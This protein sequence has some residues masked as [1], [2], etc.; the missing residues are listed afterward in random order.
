MPVIPTSIRVLGRSMLAVLLLGATALG[1]AA[2]AGS[3][4]AAPVKHALGKASKPDSGGLLSDFNGDG[5]DDLA[6]S[7]FGFEVDSQISAGAVSV[8]YGSA[9]G[10]NKLGN[11]LWTEN[12]PGMGTVAES[13]DLWGRA[14]AA[15]D[16]NGDG[17]AD[18]AI[19]DG[20]KDVTGIVDAGQANVIYGSANGL[21]TFAGPGAQ[22]FTQ[23]SPDI[24]DQAE[25]DDN[26]GRSVF[27]GDFNADGYADLAVG[28]AY[29]DVGSIQAA[30]G[31]A[32]IYGTANGLDAL[33]GPG[34]QF[35]TQDSPG[36]LEE[37]QIQDR[38][39]WN[40]TSADWNLDGYADLAISASGDDVNGFLLAGVVNVLLG[41][42]TGLTDVGNQIW[43]ED[44]P[45]IP[46][47]AEEHDAF[48]RSLKST[49][50]NGDG[51]PDLA[52]GAPGEGV[53]PTEIP[54]AGAAF[55]IYGSAIG[56][57]GLAGP[58]AQEFTQ[59]TPGI[60]DLA[61]A[62]DLFGRHLGVGDFNGDGYGD[63]V[64]G[65]VSEDVGTITDAGAAE[66][67]YGSATGLMTAGN[68]FWTQDSKHILG[69]A[70]LYDAMGRA[71]QGFDFNADGY[72]DL[73]IGVP[74]DTVAGL[75]AAGDVNVLIG[76]ATGLTATG[77]QRWTMASSG[78]VGDPQAGGLFGAGLVGLAA[79]SCGKPSLC[80]E[81]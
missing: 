50:F 51:Y 60:K 52:I 57:D 35:W 20:N 72:S 63:L 21:D 53:G 61:E 78:I 42:P 49:D 2:S 6:I 56:L 27:G 28:V 55:V 68:Q 39:G 26:F 43:T 25:F 10:L 64:S 1:S 69:I 79:G 18:L 74:G 30:G 73:A 70:E 16:F 36:I 40:L 47:V 65:V 59:D 14:L 23:D 77:N 4:A 80:N 62:N 24:L 37:S 32:V 66:V 46:D 44:S 5:Y 81:Q 54:G 67:I 29:E 33:A 48:S 71:V 15:A 3:H 19:G 31:T 75:F 22:T 34:N 17:Y 45:D 76:S 11:Q 38:M 7:D 13:G 8:I 12:S 41:S 9:L 58:G